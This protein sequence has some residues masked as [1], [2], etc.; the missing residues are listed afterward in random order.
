MLRQERETSSSI[1][2]SHEP[3]KTSDSDQLDELQRIQ[4]ELKLI[5]T[6]KPEV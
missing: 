4:K 1:K 2:G 5:N 6:T 3:R